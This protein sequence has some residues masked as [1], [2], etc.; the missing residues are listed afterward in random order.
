MLNFSPNLDMVLSGLIF[1]RKIKKT[2]KSG[3]SPI[4]SL[5][6]KDNEDLQLWFS[7][8]HQLTNGAWVASF[9]K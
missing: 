4:F 7:E 1:L 3:N 9:E 8:T 2:T 5:C 6:V